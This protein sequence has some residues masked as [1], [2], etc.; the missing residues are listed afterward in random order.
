MACCQFLKY[1]LSGDRRAKCTW[2]H[3]V[4]Q[5]YAANMTLFLLLV[6]VEKSQVPCEERIPLVHVNMFNFKRIH[7]YF[8]FGA[9]ATGALS[10]LHVRT[11][12]MGSALRAAGRG[13]L[14]VVVP[15]QIER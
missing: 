3:Y 12:R 10:M 4:V 8:E 13:T 14:T 7:R 11:P 6:S 5:A 1:N 15:V 2:Q 9:R